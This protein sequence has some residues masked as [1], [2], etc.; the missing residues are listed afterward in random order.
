M[1]RISILII[2]AFSKGIRGNDINWKDAKVT[3][4]K[5]LGIPSEV[6]DKDRCRYKFQEGG[7][8]MF[9]S[10]KFSL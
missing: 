10:V 8:R 1:T 4:T 9:M 2:T 3:L 7:D 5:E 6:R